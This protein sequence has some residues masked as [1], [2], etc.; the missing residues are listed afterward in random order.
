MKTIINKYVCMATVLAMVI[1]LF[2]SAAPSYAGIGD[3]QKLNEATGDRENGDNP[4]NVLP[5]KSEPKGYSLSYMAKATAAFNVTDHSGPFPNVVNGHPFQGLFAT[6]SNTFNVSKGTMLY[7]PVIQ[8]DDSYPAV[9]NFP[10]VAN[11][12]AVENYVYS[13]SQFG[14]Q[15]ANI[16]VDNGKVTSLDHDYLVAVTLQT[17]LT[18]F[19][20]PATEGG[21]HYMTVAAFL[22]PLNKGT[23]TVKISGYATGAAIK[24][25]CDILNAAFGVTVCTTE[26]GPFSI[27]YKVIVQ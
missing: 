11:R 5:P 13:S 3:W 27:V 16:S 7:V 22:T 6:P 10:N 9:G 1:T 25:W 14:L 19:I 26:M 4:G 18:D 15:Y 24:P 23:H 2:M 20:P 17:P 21:K 12:M 8:L